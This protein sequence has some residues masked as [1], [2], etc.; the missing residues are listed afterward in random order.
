MSP[1]G[2]DEIRASPPQESRGLGG[3]VAKQGVAKPV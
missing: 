1:S 2:L 3:R